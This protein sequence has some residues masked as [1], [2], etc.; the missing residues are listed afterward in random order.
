MSPVFKATQPLCL[1][2]MSS[3][4]FS[5]KVLLA[6]GRP[7]ASVVSVPFSVGEDGYEDG[8]LTASPDSHDSLERNEESQNKT[9]MSKGVA[10]LHTENESDK[11]GQQ[12]SRCF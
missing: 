7:R 2:T 10:W 5:S 12:K 11:S 1:P 8:R 3:Y 6:L 4:A 9:K